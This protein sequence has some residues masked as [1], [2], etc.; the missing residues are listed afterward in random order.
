MSTEKRA[1]PLEIRF[2]SP[3]EADERG[4]PREMVL[5]LAMTRVRLRH[6]E[7]GDLVISNEFASAIEPRQARNRQ[8]SET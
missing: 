1:V 4:L 7:A 6:E 5:E 8:R 3:E 2:I